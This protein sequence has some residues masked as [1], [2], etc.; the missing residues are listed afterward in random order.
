MNKNDPT[1][2]DETLVAETIVGHSVRI[3]GDFVS[4]GDI[5]IDGTVVGKVKTSKN[6][7]VGPAAKIEAD[8][9]AGSAT[10]AGT[11]A[12]NV[13]VSGLLVILQSG[14]VSG[15]VACEQLA[16]EEGAFFNG[17][18]TMTAAGK[19]TNTPLPDEE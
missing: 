6:L 18:C 17:K 11:I 3:E 9:E 13:K 5:K 19:R 14:N 12:G 15:D 8:V 1:I 4:D 2:Q 16:I 10:V 7:F